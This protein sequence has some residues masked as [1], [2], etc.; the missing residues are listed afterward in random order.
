GRG[1]DGSERGSDTRVADERHGTRTR[2]HGVQVAV[3]VVVPVQHAIVQGPVGEVGTAGRPAGE[4]DLG[5]HTGRQV[6][7]PGAVVGR[8]LPAVVVPVG[9]D[10]A[11]V[12]VD[13]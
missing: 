6:D 1:K 7:P 10:L 4:G 8:G 3:G 12:E 11:H 13:A 5:P 9:T 2:V